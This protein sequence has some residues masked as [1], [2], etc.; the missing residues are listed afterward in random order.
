MKNEIDVMKYFM[1]A[2]KVHGLIGAMD[3]L[4]EFTEEFNIEADTEV[5]KALLPF[6]EKI[7]KWLGNDV[8]EK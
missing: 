5:K 3:R 6:I 8:S 2:E 7:Q 1:A 4:I